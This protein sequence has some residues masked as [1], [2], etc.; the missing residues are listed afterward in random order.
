[1]YQK[2]NEKPFGYPA[3]ASSF[4]AWAGSYVIGSGLAARPHI[5]GGIAWV[6]TSPYPAYNPCTIACRLMAWATAQRIRLSLKSGLLMLNLS[7]LVSNGGR[8]TVLRFGSL[9]AA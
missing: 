8:N 1:M 9:C 5:P 6:A 7:Q 4:L 2:S 3:S